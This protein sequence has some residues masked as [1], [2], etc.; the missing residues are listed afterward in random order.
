MLSPRPNLLLLAIKAPI[1]IVIL[2]LLS[3]S[4]PNFSRAKN[5]S[6]SFPSVIE[7]G[8]ILADEEKG[9]VNALGGVTVKKGD[10]ILRSEEI[11]YSNN[12]EKFIINNK[13]NF[14]FIDNANIIAYEGEISKNFDKGYINNSHMI[15]NNGAFIKSSKIRLLGKNKI[16]LKDAYFSICPNPKIKTEMDNKDGKNLLVIDSKKA[17]I[18]KNN[19]SISLKK[20]KVE[21]LGI[22]VLYMPSISFP[23]PNSKKRASGFLRPSYN[24]VNNIGGGISL[25]YYF[26]IASNKDYTNSFLYF[27]ANAVYII[28]NNFRH[29]TPKGEYE[30]NVEI[31]KNSEKLKNSTKEN[32]SENKNR[33]YLSTS[34]KFKLGDNGEINHNINYSVDKDYLLDY[35]MMF[36]DYIESEISYNIENKNGYRNLKSILIQDFTENY[37]STLALPIYNFYQKYKITDFIKNK[38]SLKYEFFS[39]IQKDDILYHRYH[40]T[41][42][43]DIPLFFYGNQF[44]FSF[45]VKNNFYRNNGK[46]QKDYNEFLSRSTPEATLAWSMPF[47]KRTQ[48]FNI[49]LTPIIN[50]TYSSSNKYNNEILSLDAN[51]KEVTKE[52]IFVNNR[53][54]G[55]DIIETGLRVNYGFK[56]ELLSKNYGDTEFSL[57]QSYRENYDKN[58]PIKIKEFD[59]K[60]NIIGSLSYK[61]KNFFSSSYNFQLNEDYLNELN[62]ILTSINYKRFSINSNYVWIINKENKKKTQDQ[63]SLWYEVNLIGN[64]KQSLSLNYNFLTNKTISQTAAIKYDGCCVMVDLSIKRSNQDKLTKQETS[65]RFNFYVKGL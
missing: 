41:P 48:N 11:I 31:A 55:L 56:S 3:I 29:L 58:S 21:I 59:N 7:S 43:I 9:I 63:I 46:Y 37:N 35:K 28:K 60:S 4:F 1:S 14:S 34:G 54:S 40:I 42:Q 50:T 12:E 32:N 53:F 26:N 27:P 24:Y 5:A 10:M 61:Y 30:I 20:A 8:K 2:L 51:E 49:F 18:N 36:N 15:F 13:I 33:F 19:E 52:T 38:F 45:K 23:Y 25:R 65:Y 22:P 17:I 57:G 44:D 16:M 39:L 64:L 62:E 6:S 47:L